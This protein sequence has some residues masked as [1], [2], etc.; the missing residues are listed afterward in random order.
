[1]R[2]GLIFSNIFTTEL[3]AV[4]GVA[5]CWP[6]ESR[7][8]EFHHIFNATLTLT[9]QYAKCQMQRIKHTITGLQ[10]SADVFSGVMNQVSLSD[11]MMGESGFCSLQE[12]ST[13]LSAVC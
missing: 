7:F 13:S 5:P 10:S 11:N 4:K 8:K 3:F 9:M 12:N 2:N 6:L 1:M